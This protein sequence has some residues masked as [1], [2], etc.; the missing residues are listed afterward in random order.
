M[1][2]TTITRGQEPIKPQDHSNIRQYAFEMPT[3]DY[4]LMLNEHNGLII[5]WPSYDKN[6]PQLWSITSAKG[7]QS[8][9]GLTFNDGQK[10]RTLSVSIEDDGDYYAN[11]SPLDTAELV[12]G[13]ADKNK[14][15]LCGYDFSLKGTRAAI[16]QSEI[17]SEFLQ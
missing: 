14:F 9:E 2:S 8:C 15:T 1:Y 5:H 16:S 4:S 10:I 11:F 13:I 3:N 7:E 6:N 17:Y 12:T